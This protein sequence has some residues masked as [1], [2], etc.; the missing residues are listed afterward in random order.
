MTSFSN[1]PTLV[2]AQ[3]QRRAQPKAQTKLERKVK[4]ALDDARAGAAF[5]HAVWKRDEGL[6]RICKRKVARTLTLQANRGEVHHIKGRNV[7]PEDRYNVAAAILCC[8]GCHI[9]LQRH[10]IQAP[11]P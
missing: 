5:R 1:L 7:T 10:E 9:N 8:A 2:E 11:N 3:Q 4:K 6:C